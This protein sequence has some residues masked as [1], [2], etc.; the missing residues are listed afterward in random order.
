MTVWY[1]IVKYFTV[2]GTYVKAFF[3][4][5]CCRLYE[6]LIEDGRYIPA[7]EMCGHVDHEIIKR[8]GASF[9]V[10]FFPFLFSLIIGM[11]FLSAGSMNVYYLGEFFT[12]SGYVNIVNFIFL[13]LG[14]SFL[15]NLFP[16][17]ED[18]ITLKGLLYGENTN[19]FVKIIASPI[20]AVLYCGAYLEKWGVTFVTSVAF[21]FVLPSIYAHILPVIS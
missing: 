3:E 9:G 5:V 15:T 10:C 20:F 21:S 2:I 6:V 12:K 14:V 18:A 16:S 7:N 11:I 19:L 8:R 1:V 13:W 17:V 4:H